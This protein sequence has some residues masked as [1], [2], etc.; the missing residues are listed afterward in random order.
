M[1]Y[2]KFVCLFLVLSSVL[3]RVERKNSKFL[4]KTKLD[5]DYYLE[6]HPSTYDGSYVECRV[7]VDYLQSDTNTYARLGL[8]LYGCTKDPASGKTYAVK[9]GSTQFYVFLWKYFAKAGTWCSYNPSGS[10]KYI[11]NNGVDSSCS[12]NSKSTGGY[13]FTFYY[14]SIGS[15]IDYDTDIKVTILGAIK[16]RHSGWYTRVSGYK[17]DCTTYGSTYSEQQT[18]ANSKDTDYD[19]QIA[20]KTKCVTDGNTSLTTLKATY[21]S[22]T[23]SIS[24]KKNEIETLTTQKTTKDSTV[25]QYASLIE[26]TNS[27]N[28]ALEAQVTSGTANST[29]FQTLVDDAKSAF[30]SVMTSLIATL[31]SETDA[32]TSAQTAITGGTPNVT[33]FMNYMDSVL[34]KVS[35]E[36]STTST[37]SSSKRRR[38]KL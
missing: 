8:P 5:S 30:D 22:T 6:V 38:R 32:V 36:S 2:L 9:N 15:C 25:S 13:F 24:T 37:T 26:K 10:G 29:A 18:L 35:V 7:R 27:T 19:T 21:T 31:E 23:S 17:T 1:K 20:T 4:S 28:T 12:N 11:W 34:P 33:L 3:S 16:S 14:K